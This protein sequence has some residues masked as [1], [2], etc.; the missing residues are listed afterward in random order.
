MST[1]K[2]AQKHCCSKVS[3]SPSVI[4]LK[5]RQQGQSV[6][7]KLML[8]VFQLIGARCPGYFAFE[9]SRAFIE[10]AEKESQSDCRQNKHRKRQNAEHDIS[11]SVHISTFRVLNIYLYYTHQFANVNRFSRFYVYFQRPL[12]VTPPPRFVQIRHI[13]CTKR[14]KKA[15]GFAVCLPIDFRFRITFR[16][17]GSSTFC[18]EKRRPCVRRHCR[19]N[20][21]LRLRYSDKR[22]V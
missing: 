9:I 8:P 22:Y 1:I 6:P 3:I 10:T 7:P 4:I 15:H 11:C 14:D 20:K 17:S 12:A 18:R 21:S 2:S 5:K 16:N 19:Q 13:F